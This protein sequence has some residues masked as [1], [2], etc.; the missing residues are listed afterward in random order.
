MSPASTA[1]LLPDWFDDEP[2]F[3]CAAVPAPL[4]A[5]VHNLA[6]PSN[7]RRTALLWLAPPAYTAG[8]RWATHCLNLHPRHLGREVLATC[9][10]QGTQR[11]P[12][13]AA[14]LLRHLHAATTSP[15]GTWLWGLDA[16]LTRLPRAEGPAF[17]AALFDLR[18][19]PP[20]LLALPQ[21]F[22]D[23]GP[24]D[25]ARWLEAEPCRGLEA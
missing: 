21:A 17:W 3:D 6:N 22:R 2:A 12:A 16:L 7:T 9:Q 18:Q 19:H 15:T 20:L 13:T 8:P 23:F 11:V 24:A 25:P 10:A 14:D 5:L 4:R 1:S